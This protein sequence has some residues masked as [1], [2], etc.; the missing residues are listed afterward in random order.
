MG[1]EV[2]EDRKAKIIRYLDESG[3]K[4]RL[5]GYGLFITLISLSADDPD[6]SCYELF[7]VYAEKEF[8]VVI[9]P[10]GNKKI[11]WSLYRDCQYAL[12]TSL[13]DK[14]VYDFIR[15]CAVHLEVD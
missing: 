2:T 6:L 12:G 14:P 8:G 13:S 7:E 1:Y 10:K 11:W 15:S 5:K 9:N 3:M 4:P